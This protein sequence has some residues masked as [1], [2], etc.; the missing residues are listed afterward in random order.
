MN[1][2]SRMTISRKFEKEKLGIFF[3]ISI[4]PPYLE[5]SGLTNNKVI[6]RDVSNIVAD[7]CETFERFCLPM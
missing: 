2:K 6:L 5:V 1:F 3:Y 7:I 4:L